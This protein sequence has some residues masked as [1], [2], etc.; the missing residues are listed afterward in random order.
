MGPEP[1]DSYADDGL[2]EASLD[3][4][5]L[6]ESS[7]LEEAAAAGGGRPGDRIWVGIRIRPQSQKERE[8]RDK[9]V[10][11]AEKTGGIKFTGPVRN[12]TA[13]STFQF[14]RVFS[15]SADSD[16]VYRDCAQSVVKA[17]MEG[18]HGTGAG[19]TP[20]RPPQAVHG[21]R[22]CAR[23]AVMGPARAALKPSAPLPPQQSS[24][25]ASLA[26]ERPTPCGRCSSPRPR[27]SSTTSASAP[28]A[29]SRSASPPWRSTTRRGDA[30]L[31][32]EVCSFRRAPGFTSRPAR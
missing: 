19:E 30:P 26:L 32:T 20:M 31:P 2:D 11:E 28:A 24:R 4:A 23:T 5:N 17:S 10:W 8:A 14:D 16:E 18:F 3:E 13:K 27:I 12:Q 7:I 1:G 25:T 15:P 6:V 22:E 21:A 29:S 9:P